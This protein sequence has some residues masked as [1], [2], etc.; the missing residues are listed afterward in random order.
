M[1]RILL[2]IAM[3]AAS[4]L[5][6]PAGGSDG[7][8]KAGA[9]VH[10]I[11]SVQRGAALFMNYCHSCHSAQYMRYQRLAQDLELSEEQVEQNLM[12]GDRDLTDYM[13]ATMPAE[14]EQ[15]FGA[16][17]PDLTLT[18]R[19]RG[20]DWIFS[21]LK[22]FYLTDEGWNNTVLPNASMP[23]VLWDLQGIQRPVMETYTDESG[24]EH[25]RIAELQVDQAGSMSPEE[26]DQAL[27]DLAGFMIYLAEPAVLERENLGIWVILFL[28]LFTFLSWLLYKEYWRDVKK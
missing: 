12:F 27:R 25:T 14:S 11:A 23:H 18:A 7:L 9:N 26:Y 8:E 19:S 20:E 16:Q 6:W 4:S 10:N 22:G 28:V 13:K 17:P 1:I 2:S 3:L 15:W 24:E 5:A 21:F